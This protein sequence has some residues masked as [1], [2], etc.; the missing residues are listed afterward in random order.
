[1]LIEIQFVFSTVV[2]R[3]ESQSNATSK[4]INSKM[5]RVVDAQILCVSFC[6]KKCHA[7]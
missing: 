4:I 2:Q 7:S 6:F 5:I 1:M 3:Q